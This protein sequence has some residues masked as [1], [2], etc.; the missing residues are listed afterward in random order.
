VSLSSPKRF[1]SLTWEVTKLA[2]N[3]KY[4]QELKI[5]EKMK[6]IN[7]ITS[8]LKTKWAKKKEKLECYA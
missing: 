7:Y 4:K 2:S 8:D 3:E 5:V 6:I 1:V